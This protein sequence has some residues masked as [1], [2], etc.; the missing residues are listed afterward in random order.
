MYLPAG[1]LHA[2]LRGAGVELMAPGRW[3][4]VDTVDDLL[5][6]ANDLSSGERCP[7]TRAALARL[8]PPLEERVSA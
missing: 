1:T 5:R 2:Y 6:L 4:D 8:D 7:A 3:Y